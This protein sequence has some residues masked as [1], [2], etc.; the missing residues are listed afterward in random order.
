M[1]Q[2]WR[3]ATMLWMRGSPQA[4]IHWTSWWMACR[5]ASRKPSTEANHCSVA[6]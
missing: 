2:S 4:G 6:R 1:H 3:S 5:A